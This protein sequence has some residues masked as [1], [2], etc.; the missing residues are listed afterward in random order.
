MTEKLNYGS[1]DLHHDNR[2]TENKA[3]EHDS[4]YGHTHNVSCVLYHP[5]LNVIISNSEDK[6]IRVWDMD[7]RVLIDTIKKENDRFWILGAHPDL[8]IVGAGSDSG[9]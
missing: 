9:I 7:R 1:N 3:W 8:N 6:T 5:K 4:L 2:Y